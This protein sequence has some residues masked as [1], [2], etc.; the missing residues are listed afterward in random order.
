MPVQL[1]TSLYKYRSLSVSARERTLDTLRRRALWYASPSSFNDPFDCRLPVP[2]R[3]DPK[4][5]KALLPRLFPNGLKGVDFD[6]WDPSTPPP[7]KV[8]GMIELVVALDHKRRGLDG[9]A[10]ERPFHEVLNEMA[11]GLVARAAASVD[12]AVGVLTLAAI[13]D[14]ILLWTNYADIHKGI[15]IEL[16][17]EAV[18]LP[19]LAPVVYA[20]DVPP[21]DEVI[22]A[23][24]LH[25]WNAERPGLLADMAYRAATADLSPAAQ[26]YWTGR[27]LYAKSSEWRY[28]QE[29]RSVYEASG[30]AELG[31]GAFKS[32]IVGAMTADNDIQAV[33]EA[34]GGQGP[35]VRLRR[36]IPRKHTFGLDIVD[37]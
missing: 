2:T 22:E 20:D 33:R 13:P 37:F 7:K 32:V 26:W 35:E 19:R 14:H 31:S 23:M 34:L 4:A 12:Q 3:L 29:W 17:V 18:T 24:A 25:Q 5:W 30:L 6:D 27:W 15:C 10:P 11:S 36:A 16:D 8:Q 28:E 21:Y 9:D 1:P